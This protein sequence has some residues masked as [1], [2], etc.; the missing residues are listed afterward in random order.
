MTEERI[1]KWLVSANNDYIAAGNLLFVSKEKVITNVVCFLAQQSAEKFL[2]SFL[3]FKS[4]PFPKT[5]NLELLI[6]K[7]SRL[8]PEFPDID[9]G[10]LTS[11]NISMRYPDEFRIPT[12][13]EAKESYNTAKTVRNV[14]LERMSI[15]DNEIN[16]FNN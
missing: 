16:L 12:I 13:E 11:Y 10:R 9:A 6:E 3:I 4:E 14:I 7:C 2:K 15:S 8:N 5:H 1:K